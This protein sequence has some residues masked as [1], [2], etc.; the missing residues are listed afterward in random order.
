MNWSERDD[1]VRR[2]LD[3]AWNCKLL[4]IGRKTRAVRAVTIWFA[5]D[6]EDV[7]LAGSPEGPHWWRNLRACE[8][9]ELRIAGYHLHGRARVAG[10]DEEAEAIRA[11][12]V[13]RYLAARL[14]RPFGGYTRSSAARVVIDRFERRAD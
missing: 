13:E 2:A 6:G 8:D 5:F 11:C 4:T 10:G 7:V 12:F 1:E 14:A 9:V 3:R